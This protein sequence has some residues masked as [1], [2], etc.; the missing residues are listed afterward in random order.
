MTQHVSAPVSVD[1]AVSASDP[2]GLSSTTESVHFRKNQQKRQKLL[3][4]KLENVVTRHYKTI[5]NINNVFSNC[6]QNLKTKLRYIGLFA[7]CTN[8]GLESERNV[9]Y[10]TG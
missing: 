5:S 4:W 9:P 7:N 6:L 2:D 3:F 10:L 1:S 8:T